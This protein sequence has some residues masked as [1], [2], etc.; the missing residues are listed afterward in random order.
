[1]KFSRAVPTVEEFL[2]WYR[3]N[4]LSIEKSVARWEKL[5]PV[6]S[7]AERKRVKELAKVRR[8]HAFVEDVAPDGGLY[9]AGPRFRMSKPRGEQ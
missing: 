5:H 7:P 3:M 8:K 4:E 9:S 1:M 2:S 6:E